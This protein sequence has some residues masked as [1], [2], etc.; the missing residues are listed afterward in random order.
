MSSCLLSVRF[1]LKTL[2]AIL[3]VVTSGSMVAA[4]VSPLSGP[5]GSRVT[6]NPLAQAR[7]FGASRSSPSGNKWVIRDL[8]LPVTGLPPSAAV[9]TPYA[10]DASGDVALATCPPAGCDNIVPPGRA[11]AFLYDYRLARLI[12]LAKL[13]GRFNPPAVDQAVPHA[14]NNRG[15]IVGAVVRTVGSNTVS[16]PV[17]W[18]RQGSTGSRIARL[19]ATPGDQG[20]AYGVNDIGVTVGSVYTGPY[21]P[22]SFEA[23]NAVLFT[24]GAPVLLAS[25]A[26]GGGSDAYGING[27]GT[28]VGDVF[29]GSAAVFTGGNAIPIPQQYQCPPPNDVCDQNAAF[30]INKAGDVLGNY[31]TNFFDQGTQSYVGFL[32]K[33]NSFTTVAPTCFDSECPIHYEPGDTDF[34]LALNAKDDFVGSFDGQPWVSF[35]PVGDANGLLPPNSGWRIISVAA[36]NDR[37]QIVGQGYNAAHGSDVRAFLLEPRH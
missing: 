9:P 3:L 2:I 13:P 31:V 25:N 16:V 6:M 11:E 7:R 23:G 30:A 18:T 19:D 14:L 36:I 5:L 34:V 27:V 4:D 17:M 29:A 33:D 35:S 20:T 15:Q 24:G 26:P 10:I 37:R 12:Q 21:L 8:G 28:A 1:L 22:N 32:W